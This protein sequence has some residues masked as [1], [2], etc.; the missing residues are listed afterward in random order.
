M[1]GELKCDDSDNTSYM[2]KSISSKVNPPG[3]KRHTTRNRSFLQTK[4]RKMNQ[5]RDST[6]F[7]EKEAVHKAMVTHN[8]AVKRVNLDLAASNKAKSSSSFGLSHD[9]KGS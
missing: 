1:M 4:N 3:G 2:D 8:Y 5:L 7:S 6:A 9:A